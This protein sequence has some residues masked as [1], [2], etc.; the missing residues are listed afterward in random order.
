MGNR[1]N[2]AD[3]LKIELGDIANKKRL[4]EL[5]IDTIVNAA[6]PTL[7]GSSQGVDGAIHK[8]IDKKLKPS[9]S[10]FNEKIREE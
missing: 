7:M 10:S 5:D 2:I 6:K 8:K 9:K 1:K 3:M 4:K